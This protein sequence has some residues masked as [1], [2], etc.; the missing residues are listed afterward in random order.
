LTLIIGLVH[1][2]K[3]YLAGD[4]IA[5]NGYT[6]HNTVQPKVFK[7]G[8]LYMG[9]TDSFRM[10]QLLEH[11]LSVPARTVGQELLPWLV[12]SLVPAVRT[13]LTQGGYAQNS[14]GNE[15]GG[16]FLI[17]AE[18]RIFEMQ[19]EYSVLER[20]DGYAAVGSG[21]DYALASLHTRAMQEHLSSS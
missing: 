11:N 9:Y 4:T 17:V 8:V 15:R 5:S 21:E 3:A 12:C 14:S 18:H 1:D 20:T 16:N 10:G 2:G 19:G 7:N 6:Y 13:C